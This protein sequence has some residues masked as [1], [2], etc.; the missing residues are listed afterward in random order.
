MK[1]P[2]CQHENPENAKFYME[3]AHPLQAKEQQTL[4]AF[5][6]SVHNSKF[7]VPDVA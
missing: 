3:C 4:G 7:R 2:K 6:Q 1:C 5:V